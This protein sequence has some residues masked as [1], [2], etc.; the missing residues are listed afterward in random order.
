MAAPA[1]IP[2]PCPSCWAVMVTPAAPTSS[3][4]ARV[5]PVGGQCTSGDEEGGDRRVAGE[6]GPPHPA[7]VEGGEVAGEED[8]IDLGGPRS[9]GAASAWVIAVMVVVVLGG[10]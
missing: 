6:D 5:T 1:M 4:Q 10:E 9:P 2:S 7:E 3:R 8:A